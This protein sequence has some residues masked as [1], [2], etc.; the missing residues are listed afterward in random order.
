MLPKIHFPTAA[1]GAASRLGLDHD[2]GVQRVQG[3]H[4]GAEGGVGI[5][6][7]DKHNGAVDVSLPL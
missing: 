2:E 5:P 3:H 7:D 6:E 1:R 4:V